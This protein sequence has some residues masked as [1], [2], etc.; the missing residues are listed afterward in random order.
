[1]LKCWHSSLKV[2][3]KAQT[4]LLNSIF[5]KTMVKMNGQSGTSRTIVLY[6]LR[7]F[8]VLRTRSALNQVAL[9]IDILTVRAMVYESHK[10]DLQLYILFK[11]HRELISLSVRSLQQ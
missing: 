7:K 3:F 9:I 11:L 6:W 1:M 10:V 5:K 8:Q 2:W 4:F